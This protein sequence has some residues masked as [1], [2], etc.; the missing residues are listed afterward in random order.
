M[1]PTLVALGVVALATVRVTA[2]SGQSTVGRKTSA[3]EAAIKGKSS[4]LQ[5]VAHVP[6]THLRSE[7]GMR[8]LFPPTNR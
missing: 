5:K 2:Q 1:F 7:Q 3:E 8:T 4:D 6:T